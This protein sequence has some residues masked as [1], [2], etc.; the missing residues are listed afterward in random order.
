MN[1]EQTPYIKDGWK[2]IKQK[3]DTITS[4]LVDYINNF[5]SPSYSKEELKL[6]I[7]DSFRVTKVGSILIMDSFSGHKTEDVN[8]AL[9]ESNLDL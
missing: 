2:F 7:K 3:N 1:P 8:L 6:L 4:I 5:L 9:K